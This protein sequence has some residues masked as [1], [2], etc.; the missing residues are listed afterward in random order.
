MLRRVIGDSEGFVQVLNE[1]REKFS[2]D[3]LSLCAG[4][5]C[6]RSD[7]VPHSDG[8]GQDA[9][10]SPSVEVVHNEGCDFFFSVYRES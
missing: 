6:G 4:G 10:Y 2:T 9:L 8:T 7:I 3:L 1:G 5:S